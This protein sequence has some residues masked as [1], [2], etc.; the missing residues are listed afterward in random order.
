MHVR[1]PLFQFVILWICLS[2][3]I[4]KLKNEKVKHTISWKILARSR[5]RTYKLTNFARVWIVFEDM[6]VECS[7]TCLQMFRT[8]ITIVKL[9]IS[10]SSSFNWKAELAL[11]LY[12]P[13]S[14]LPPPGNVYLAVKDHLILVTLGILAYWTMRHNSKLY[15]KLRWRAMLSFNINYSSEL[16]K[17]LSL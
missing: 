15:S 4:W 2:Y 9:S 3:F 16:N 12:N 8:C 11:F 6:I 1:T 14:H 17:S 10:P 5:S 13:A 7:R